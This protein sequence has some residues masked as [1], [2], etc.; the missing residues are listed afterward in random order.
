MRQ[1]FK[2]TAT[3]SEQQ[4]PALRIIIIRYNGCIQQ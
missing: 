1:V 4:K 2:T 3:F